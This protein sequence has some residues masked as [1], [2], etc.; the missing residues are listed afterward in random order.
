MTRASL[1]V[2]LCACSAADERP[3]RLA[4]IQEAIF[5]PSCATSNCHSTLT[6]VAGLDLEGLTPGELRAELIFRTLV[7]AGD[8]AASPL[9]GWLRGDEGVPVRMPPDAPLP[10]ADIELVERWIAAGAP[11]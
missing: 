6:R 3:A 8:P 9:L 1:F 10:A 5:I 11:E 7:Y 2:L 4:Y